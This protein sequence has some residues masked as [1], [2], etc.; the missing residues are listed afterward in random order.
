M[1]AGALIRPQRAI[2]LRVI[3]AYQTVSDEATLLL[4]YMSPA[5]LLA[6]ERV[7]LR[8]LCQQPSLQELRQRLWPRQTPWREKRFW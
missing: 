3:R 5:D 1:T 8:R 4:A 7:M 6:Q 2:A